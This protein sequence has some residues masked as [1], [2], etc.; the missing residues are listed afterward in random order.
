M[1]DEFRFSALEEGGAKSAS[2]LCMQREFRKKKN[3]LYKQIIKGEEHY[4]I[5]NH[6]S[7]MIQKYFTSARNLK[8]YGIIKHFL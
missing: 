2:T 4:L 5:E 6:Q 7:H 1:D 3:K 8:L